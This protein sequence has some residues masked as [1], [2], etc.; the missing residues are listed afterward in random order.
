METDFLLLWCVHHLPELA[1][2]D[3]IERWSSKR[4]LVLEDLWPIFENLLLKG[5][6]HD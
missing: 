6:G 1:E 4:S 3:R 2:S 5:E